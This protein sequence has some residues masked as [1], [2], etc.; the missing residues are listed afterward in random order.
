MPFP[1]STLTGISATGD[2]IAGPGAPLYIVNGLPVACMGDAVAGAACTGVITTSMHPTML[3]L[4]RPVASLTCTVT[5]VNPI[6]G[7]PVATVEAVS[8]GLNFLV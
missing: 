1:V 3:I 7:I 5:G 4:G 6:T 8:A 2:A